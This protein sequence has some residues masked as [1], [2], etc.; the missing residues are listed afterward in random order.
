MIEATDQST[1][2]Q[3]LQS[4]GQRT[5]GLI[6]SIDNLDRPVPGLEWTVG[7]V[8]TH[9]LIAVRGNAQAI[10]GEAP[11][12]TPYIPDVDGYSARMSVAMHGT[13]K[14]EPRRDAAELGR[15]LREQVNALVAA[16]QARPGDDR[17]DTPWYGAGE[18]LCVRAGI[19]LMTGELVIHGLDIAR[20]LGRPWPISRHEALQIICP[21]TLEMMPKVV[22]KTKVRGYDDLY[23]VNFRG[24]PNIGFRFVDGTVDIQDWSA[25]DRRAAVTLSADPVA[26]LLLAYGR[27]SQ[28]PLIAQGRLIAY[29]RKPWLALQ[30][31]GLFANP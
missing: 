31:R 6:G 22:D 27:K 28:W 23:R 1:A 26:F 13:L 10:R 20:G 11:G 21:S 19:S 15:L 12:I 18:Q 7:D 14:A 29:G 17:Y 9:V 8:A 30:M 24:G 3:T 5:A 2:V 4:A 16:V 25:W